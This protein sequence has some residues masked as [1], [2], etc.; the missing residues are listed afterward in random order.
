MKST[1]DLDKLDPK[2]LFRLIQEG[3]VEGAYIDPSDPRA[4]EVHDGLA[5]QDPKYKNYKS[6]KRR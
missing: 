4:E 6:P 5:R 1:V 2:E 3:I